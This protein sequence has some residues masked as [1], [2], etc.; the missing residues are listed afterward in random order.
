MRQ[1]VELFEMAS[2][3]REM[4]QEEVR[5]M[6]YA[7]REMSMK[8]HFEMASVVGQRRWRLLEEAEPLMYVLWLANFIV[9]D[10]ASCQRIVECYRAGYSG[11][12]RR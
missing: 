7:I 4:S 10:E 12:A 5:A 8:E 2:L 3:E 6:E 11:S 9:L 1:R